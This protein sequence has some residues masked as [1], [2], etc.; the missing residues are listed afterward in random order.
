[1]SELGDTPTPVEEG[2]E[3]PRNVRKSVGMGFQ[4][5]H[6]CGSTKNKLTYAYGNFY[7]LGIPLNHGFMLCPPCRNILDTAPQ[8]FFEM[9][10]VVYEE[11]HSYKKKGG[12]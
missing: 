11:R 8:Q 5:C 1:M 10:D 4:S 12:D 3:A 7:E 2:D 6:L 9:W